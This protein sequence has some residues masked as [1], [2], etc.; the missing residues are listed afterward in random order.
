MPTTIAVTG[1]AEERIAPELAAVSL[2][3]GGSGAARDDVA[4]RTGQAHERLLAEVRRP[5]TLTL[6]KLR[7]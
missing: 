3:V 5:P 6:R 4:A 1:H 7:S 2:S